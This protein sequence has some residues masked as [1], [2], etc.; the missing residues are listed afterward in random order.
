MAYQP[1]DEEAYSEDIY[2]EEYEPTLSR[3]PPSSR[4]TTYQDLYYA[5]EIANSSP[6]PP[7]RCIAGPSQ[8]P[9]Y[10]PEEINEYE[11][12][13]PYY[14][15]DPIHYPSSIGP[16]HHQVEYDFHPSQFRTSQYLS[17][18]PAPSFRMAS[19][20]H[21][22]TH[23]RPAQYQLPLG[24]QRPENTSQAPAPPP[25]RGSNPR[26]S[27]GIRLRPVSELPDIYRGIFKFGVFNAVQSTCF[28]TVF[29]T[30]ENMVI[31][32]PTGS[33]KTVLFELAIIR[34]LRQAKDSGKSV[35]CV[36]MA[37]TKAL[38]SER[39]RD[40]S[41]K[42]DA[43]GIRCCE[44]TGDT[45][46]FGKGAWGD[47]KGAT[48]IITTGEKWD[49]LTR[50]WAD[51]GQILSQIQL[52]LVDEVHILNES[53][54]STL[55]VVISRMK[56][57]GSAVRFVLVSATVPNIQDIASWIG[58]KRRDDAATVFKFGE[59]FR[60]CKL[61]R[62]V[63]GV[64]RQRGD[65][66]FSFTRKLDFKLFPALQAHSVGKPILVFVSTRKG[67]LMTAEQLLKDYSEAEQTKQPLPWS[68]P[69]RIDQVFHEK[70]LIALAASGIGVHHAGLTIDDRRATEDLYLKGF[71]RV[72]V[73][74]STLAVGVNLP[75]HTVVIKGVQIFQNNASVE[76]SDL[77]VMQMLGRAGRPQFDKDGIAIIMCETELEGKYRELVQGKT[78]VESSLHT[79]LSEHINSE[80]GL[81]TIT[82]KNPAHYALGKGDN[83]SWEERVDDMV[84]DSVQ[85]LRETN[86][87]AGAK[88]GDTSGVL[89]STEFGD[90][91]SKFYIRQSTMGLILALPERP[92]LRD[93][94]EM[95]S[96]SEE[97]AETKLRSSEKTIFNKLRKHND[98]RFEVKKIEK[99]SDKVFL[100]IQAVLG[101][102]SLNAPEYKS[103]DSQPQL[104][105]FSVFKHVSR[106]A[107][108]VVEVAI[109]KKRGAQLKYGL[110]LVRC[111]TAK[112]W[113]DRPVVLRQIESIGEK[114]LKVLAEN[115]ITSLALLR[116][117]ETYRI[118]T[119][120]NRRPPFGN[121]VLASVR[122]LP[123]YTL[124]IKEVE[125]HT[126]GG[127]GPVEIELSI[128]CGL[129]AEPL[130]PSKGRKQKGRSQMT[131]ILT[132]TSDSEMVDFRRIPT[133]ALKETKTFEISAELTKP[134][135]S[136][137]V[138]ITSESIAGVTV[139]Q[140]YRPQ[141]PSREYPTRDTRPPTAMDL[142]LEG[143]ENDPDFWN[144]PVD[145]NGDEIPSPA[146][147][148]R[149]LTKPKAKKGET[150]QVSRSSAQ[151][152]EV[153]DKSPPKPKKLP[154]G[155]YKCNHPCKDK[156]KCRHMCCRDGLAEPPKQPKK[157]A[158][159][160]TE[161][162]KESSPV[163]SP[164]QSTKPKKMNNRPDPT[165]QNLE[166]LHERTNV[167][168]KLPE[169]RRLKLEPA[170]EL[171]RKK[172]P[173][174]NFSVELTQLNDGEPP[175]SYGIADLDDED[176]DLPAPHELLKPA[177]SATKKQQSPSETNYSDSEI[178]SLIRQ[179]PS[180]LMQD[181]AKKPAMSSTSLNQNMR[182]AKPL[183]STPVPSRKRNQ[184]PEDAHPPPK[185]PRFDI[186]S[187][188]SSSSPPRWEHKENGPSSTRRGLPL[189]TEVSDESEDRPTP[190]DFMGPPANDDTYDE[191]DEFILDCDILP[192]TPALTAS[193]DQ[194]RTTSDISMPYPE[195]AR[196][197]N[198][199][200]PEVA[201]TS[202]EAGKDEAMEYDD[203]DDDLEA[204]DAWLNSGAVEIVG[205]RVYETRL[206]NLFSFK[207]YT[208]VEDIHDQATLPDKYD[209]DSHRRRPD[210]RR[211]W[212][213]DDAQSEIIM[214]W[215]L[216]HHP[217]WL[218]RDINEKPTRGMSVLTL[219]K[220]FVGAYGLE[221]G[222]VGVHTLEEG[223]HRVREMIWFDSNDVIPGDRYTIDEWAPLAKALQLTREPRWYLKMIS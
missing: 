184:S 32:A 51:H 82:N 99:T 193:S 88:A 29:Q 97:L 74:T 136:V 98:I 199:K 92:T 35:K 67:V 151:A 208:I 200:A 167:S 62:H 44:L 93:I 166:R 86:L 87:I 6:S 110:E 168:L 212:I 102:I 150:S 78:I 65:N 221:G 18:P 80:I 83:Q 37:P 39:Q 111:L 207:L 17:P 14:E 217:Q 10:E 22:Q 202:R 77:D 48:I 12:D 112:A 30:D 172:R 60:P 57:R 149:D 31:S 106:I 159:P 209:A 223:E 170:S 64:P 154:N 214:S 85:K 2:P 175:V 139:T 119:L 95:I 41:S 122:E 101:G 130:N 192:T 49:S 114:S 161:S 121:E 118:E 135:Q 141:V 23:R 96:S 174:I 160:S 206:S 109:V 1:Y 103:G 11:D 81:G 33:G 125:V 7:E 195:P 116:K 72:V 187:R 19:A 137:V 108:V 198:L 162:K 203:Q 15:D 216:Q 163:A 134:S 157:R 144:M 16:A 128:T 133:K 188:Q 147:V 59:E 115:G 176:D 123:Q 180:E 205:T 21:A 152:L 120:L 191:D 3:A 9:R 169:G 213:M 142:D 186:A 156:T 54:G 171:K 90:I 36:Y 183:L 34:M 177:K 179:A 194:S 52:F 182:V 164:I 211:G 75:A 38:C 113:E 27:S 196:P 43:L 94:L 56:T 126:N 63:V 222:V 28:D 76:Y 124:A 68:H 4:Y 129:A 53:R 132:L 100:L 5:D 220:R 66:D 185:R 50:N 24:Q 45:V 155:N 219:G 8:L 131:A 215:L 79:N 153:A 70:R 89:T 25:R 47:A 178:D 69:K 165:M 61:T 107:R 58:N 148:V 42:F 13:V 204:L 104:E 190:D 20:H 145:Q 127:K 140:A 189:F 26:N 117:Q 210:L 146:P 173:P 40:W 138:L 73:A 46:Q 197:L 71:L 181:I 55:E 91:M 105:A 158:E 201:A 143:L 218:W 84:M